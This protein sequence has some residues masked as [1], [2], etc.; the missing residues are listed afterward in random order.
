MRSRIL[1]CASMSNP[2]GSRT[3]RLI[4]SQTAA[5]TA[6]HYALGRVRSI[7]PR[8]ATRSGHCW[9][10]CCRHRETPAA[11]ADAGRNTPAAWY[12][13]RSSTCRTPAHLGTPSPVPHGADRQTHRGH[14]RIR[15]AAS[16]VG[17]RA[18]IRL[19]QQAPT[20]RTRLRNT[21]HP[22]RSHGPPRNDQGHVTP[23]RPHRPLTPEFRRPLRSS[24]PSRRQH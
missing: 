12:L 19:D 14:H 13:T 9:N 23:A 17:R 15:R 8:P 2:S 21:P 5:A 6:P 3:F 16:R 7:H 20:L 1:I 18:H 22:P 24:A 11:R 4:F 10:R